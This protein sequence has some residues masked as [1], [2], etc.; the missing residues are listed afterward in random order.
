MPS[1]AR[2]RA[3]RSIAGLDGIVYRLI[4]D[5]MAAIGRGEAD[6]PADLLQMLATAVDTEGDG[7]GL[8]R[9]QVRDE[10]VTLFLAGHETTS[11]A[12]TWTWMLLSQN[13]EVRTR[14]VAEI[15]DVLG[16]R[17]PTFEDLEAL[18][19]T[20]LVLKEAMRLYPPAFVLSRKSVADT[21]IGGYEVPAGSEVIVWTYYTHR[22]AR[23]YP[24]PEAFR[25][26][27]FEPEAYAKLPRMAYLPFGG[28]PR[29]CIGANFSLIEA[30]LILATLA[31]RL[32]FELPAGHR[33]R[34]RTGVTLA[35]RGGLPMAV[36]RRGP[37]VVGGGVRARAS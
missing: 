31:Q 27:R 12:L 9:K 22:D 26:E 15:D 19:L 24:D 2:T 34:H 8:P 11:H 4:D 36:T 29:A 7:E 10:L 20:E 28:G 17:A 3:Q 16:G 21:E 18:P 37:T 6:L 23:W 1:P 33:V 5:R 30:R 35:P 32:R 25:P 13:P 14:L